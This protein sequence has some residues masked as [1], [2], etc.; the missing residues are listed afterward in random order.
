MDYCQIHFPFDEL[1]QDLCE[2]I[3]VMVNHI[4]VML[5]PIHASRTCKYMQSAVDLW[6]VSIVSLL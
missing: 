5:D 1:L 2:G 3:P 4:E 6:E